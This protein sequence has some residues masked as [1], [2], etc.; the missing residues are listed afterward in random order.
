MKLNW[1]TPAKKVIHLYG[2]QISQMTEWYL[3]TGKEEEEL[4]DVPE[5]LWSKGTADVGLIQ[6]IKPVEITP[7]GSIRPYQIQY[8]LKPE[9]IIG[10]WPIIK[11]LLSRGIIRECPD[12]PCNTPLFPIKKAAPSEGWHMAQDLQAVNWAIIPRAPLVPDPHNLLNDLDP[13]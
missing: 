3:L 11:D 10:I 2:R 7:K 4:K 1:V 12:S 8:P 6:G 9:A 5:K 13:N